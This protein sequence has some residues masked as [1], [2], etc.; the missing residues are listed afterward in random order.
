MEFEVFPAYINVEPSS[1]FS[2]GKQRRAGVSSLDFGGTNFHCVLEEVQTFHSSLNR[3]HKTP[4]CVFIS[5]ATPEELDKSYQKLIAELE[6]KGDEKR[7]RQLLESY[8]KNPIPKTQARLGFVTESIETT[9]EVLGQAVTTLESKAD[10]TEWN[11]KNIAYRE[12]SMNTKGKVV[13]LFSGQGSQYMNM[14]KELLYN[15]PV[16]TEPF[17]TLDEL[18]TQSRNK[19]DASIEPLSDLVFLN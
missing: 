10:Q 14:G 19:T 3:P 17:N 1:G 12:K 4:K 8:V 15:F 7:H 13:A 5:A 16:M 9:L 11:A 18:F 6:T 2:K